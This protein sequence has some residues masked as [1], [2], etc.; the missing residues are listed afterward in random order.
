MP[1]AREFTVELVTEAG[2]RRDARG[3][4]SHMC[5]PEEQRP[6]ALLEPSQPG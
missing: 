5:P 1:A 2:D 3:Q 6:S 4:Q